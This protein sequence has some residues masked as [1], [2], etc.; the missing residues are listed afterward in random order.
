MKLRLQRMRE[1]YLSGQPGGGSRNYTSTNAIF[2]FDDLRFLED[3]PSQ[4]GSPTGHIANLQNHGLVIWQGLKL[5]DSG[6]EINIE[7]DLTKFVGYIEP[8]TVTIAM[9]DGKSRLDNRGYG[10]CRDWYLDT[11]GDIYVDEYYAF[12]CPN[13]AYSIRS[14]HALARDALGTVVLDPIYEQ[15]VKTALNPVTIQGS[16]MYLCASTGQ[17]VKCVKVQQKNLDWLKSLPPKQLPRDADNKVP[18]QQVTDVSTAQVLNALS[19]RYT[20]ITQLAYLS[21]RALRE[22]DESRK[23]GET[24]HTPT[25]KTVLSVQR[26]FR[27]N[28]DEALDRLTAV[29]HQ[30]DQIDMSL[31]PM[32]HQKTYQDIKSRIEKLTHDIAHSYGD[33][34]SELELSLNSLLSCTESLMEKVAAAAT[35]PTYAA[36]DDSP[37]RYERAERNIVHNAACSRCLRPGHTLETCSHPCQMCHAVTGHD[38]AICPVSNLQQSFA[39]MTGDDSHDISMDESIEFSIGMASANESMSDEQTLDEVLRSRYWLLHQDIVPL[40]NAMQRQNGLN[41]P[42]VN[43]HDGQT[44]LDSAAIHQYEILVAAAVRFGTGI[45]CG[46]DPLLR[47]P[48]LDGKPYLEY[49]DLLPQPMTTVYSVTAVTAH[50]LNNIVDGIDPTAADSELTDRQLAAISSAERYAEEI[51]SMRDMCS[52]YLAA[53]SGVEQ[54][55]ESQGGRPQASQSTQ[56]TVDGNPPSPFSDRE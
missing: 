5:V 48:R 11:K 31:P 9:A 47:A 12:Y 56:S 30:D 34:S 23:R 37:I 35:R 13:A 54:Q 27:M 20:D 53:R 38:H 41:F 46:D 32:Q 8:S 51:T 55:N 22:E 42:F 39:N 2:Q 29:H 26:A 4:H 10:L 28:A 6:A 24:F 40:A 50:S 45:L 16:G 21:D 3:L 19:Q 49:K 18:G 25:D 52:S 1:L 7:V 43:D 17:S 36:P 15:T 14:E 44:V 33:A